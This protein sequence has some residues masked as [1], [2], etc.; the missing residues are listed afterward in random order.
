MKDKRRYGQFS[1]IY[2]AIAALIAY[3][4]VQAGVVPQGDVPFLIEAGSAVLGALGGL[5]HAWITDT[6][7]VQQAEDHK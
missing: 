2:G 1:G 3:A 6:D 5:L 4:L 7:G